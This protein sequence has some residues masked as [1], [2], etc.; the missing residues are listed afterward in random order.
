[1]TEL[2]AVVIIAEFLYAWMIMPKLSPKRSGPELLN[3]LLADEQIAN[4][5]FRKAGLKFQN[6]L[7]LS[8]CCPKCGAY[9]MM[10]YASNPGHHNG[11][12]LSVVI[13]CAAACDRWDLESCDAPVD[14]GAERTHWW[15]DEYEVSEGLETIIRSLPRAEF[16]LAMFLNSE[17]ARL[18]GAW[19]RTVSATS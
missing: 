16:E 3:S 2:G 12:M 8:G 14:A 5:L 10:E 7:A 13:A 6:L 1:M 19:L 18:N 11:R 15:L 4:H 17:T 9:L